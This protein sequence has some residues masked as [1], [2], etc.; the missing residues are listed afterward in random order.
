LGYPKA[1]GFITVE[2]S[3]MTPVES[4]FLILAFT[5]FVLNP[6]ERPMLL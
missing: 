1:A 5:A 3:R 2:K 6:T 4:N